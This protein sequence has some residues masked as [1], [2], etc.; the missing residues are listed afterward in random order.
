[1]EPSPRLSQLITNFSNWGHILK[2]YGY[3]NQ[4]Q[5]IMLFLNRKT[6]EWWERNSRAFGLWLQKYREILYLNDGFT[7]EKAEELLT[8]NLYYKYKIRVILW[9]NKH[10]VSF[11]RFI[12]KVEDSVKLCISDC[13]IRAGRYQIDPKSYN[14]PYKAMKTKNIDTSCLRITSVSKRLPNF[15]PFSF[16]YTRDMLGLDE[17]NLFLFKR[18]GTYKC[19][20]N[21]QHR[22]S[23]IMKTESWVIEDLTVF[24]H[25]YRDVII[26][27][28]D[29]ADIDEEKKDSED[30]DFKIQVRFMLIS[31]FII[32]NRKLNKLKL[33]YIDSKISESDIK[34][35]Q[36]F[37]YFPYLE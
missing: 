17:Y 32:R 34:L 1:M 10:I 23:H 35:D 8:G 2:Y 6:K 19:S 14:L 26:N 7:P 24:A 25:H 20:E 30:K 12:L 36:I 29:K 21:H 31:L 11:C 3:F 5:K 27:P 18:V 4:C 28:A 22:I 13:E 33:I 15:S 9:C 37:Q 16:Y